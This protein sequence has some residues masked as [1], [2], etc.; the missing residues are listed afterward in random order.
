MFSQFSVS[1]DAFYA[2]FYAAY[3]LEATLECKEPMKN[4]GNY[5]DSIKYYSLLNKIERS[6]PDKNLPFDLGCASPS[7]LLG[8][9][10]LVFANSPNI[11]TGLYNLEKYNSIFDDS[12]DVKLFKEE[13]DFELVISPDSQNEHEGRHINALLHLLRCAH[14]L[15]DVGIFFDINITIGID[16]TY[17]NRFFSNRRLC[18]A[19]NFNIVQS[20]R[21]YLSINEKFTSF[22]IHTAG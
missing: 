14:L 2:L 3:R 6:N 10:G 21:N 15:F 18:C 8:S 20:D 13:D 19:N 4:H 12:L 1:S 9:A 16:T 5:V 17:S 7:H 22:R 11:K